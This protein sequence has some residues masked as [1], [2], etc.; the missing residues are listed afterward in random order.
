MGQRSNPI[1]FFAVTIFYLPSCVG[2]LTNGA[3]VECRLCKKVGNSL[4]SIA[5]GSKGPLSLVSLLL[6]LL[7]L[8]PGRYTAKH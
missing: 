3:L 7:N 1:V 2:W 5:V 4:L 6:H 8:S